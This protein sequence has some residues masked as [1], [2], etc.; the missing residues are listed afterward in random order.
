MDNMYV[1]FFYFFYIL[2]EHYNECLVYYENL[3]VDS[4]NGLGFVMP[5]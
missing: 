4:I 5:L 2:L 1:F 3:I